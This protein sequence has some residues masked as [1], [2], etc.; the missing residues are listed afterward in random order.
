MESKSNK[1]ALKES[2]EPLDLLRMQ[3]EVALLES[4]SQSKTLTAMIVIGAITY[5]GF[6]YWVV[7]MASAL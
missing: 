7:K 4:M 2:F 6:I 3:P 1:S 5:S